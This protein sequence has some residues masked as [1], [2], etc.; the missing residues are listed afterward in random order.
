MPGFDG[1]G[2]RGQGAMTGGGFGFCSVPAGSRRVG[3]AGRGAFGGRGR[4]QRNRYWMT[5]QP[6]WARG[7]GPYVPTRETDM[8]SL[9]ER[10][11]LLEREL[12]NIRQQLGRSQGTTDSPTG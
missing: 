7:A 4:G 1:T 3:Y 9:Q 2:P 12:Q 11:D 5:G 10:A 8:Q 6:L